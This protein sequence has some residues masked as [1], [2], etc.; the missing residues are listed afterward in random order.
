MTQPLPHVLFTGPVRG[1]V[2]LADGTDVDVTPERLELDSP[3]QVAEVADLI[4]RKYA[5]EGHPHHAHK[6]AFV[7][8]APEKKK[9]L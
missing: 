4:G 8:E 7:Y 2:T 5:E 9:A 6:D 3:E 1:V